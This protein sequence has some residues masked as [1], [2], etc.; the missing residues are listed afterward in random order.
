MRALEE[1]LNAIAVAPEGDGL[2]LHGPM[3]LRSL[4]MPRAADALHL[5]ADDPTDAAARIVAIVRAERDAWGPPVVRED[6]DAR[7]V[8]TTGR[9][10]RA[11]VR[12]DRTPP[13]DPT[14]GWV[15]VWGGTPVLGVRPETEAAAALRDGRAADLAWLC[16]DRLL[17]GDGVA[18]QLAAWG[19]PAISLADAPPGRWRD[20]VAARLRR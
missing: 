7:V 17:D 1:L 8:E 10:G 9:A 12:I 6:G 2:V 4:G 20:R 3:L 11:A 14:P 18:D 16:A 15:E 19:N 13:L 5:Y